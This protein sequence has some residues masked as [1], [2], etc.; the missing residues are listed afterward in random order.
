MS[1]KSG[2]NLIFTI[3]SWL[4]I[5]FCFLLFPAFVLETTVKSYFELKFHNERQNIFTELSRRNESILPF[6]DER[7]YFQKLLQKTFA[8]AENERNSLNYLAKAIQRLKKNYPGQLEF[9]VWNSKGGIVEKLT[10]EKKYKYVLKKLYRVLRDVKNNILSGNPT[11]IKDIQSLK[12]S[13]NIVKQFLGRVFL[14]DTLRFPYLAE[15]KAGLILAD[16]GKERPYFW[17]QIGEK[18]G[19]LTFIKWDLIK[20][21]HGLL[22]L[23]QVVNKNHPD[24]FCGF[25]HIGN[26]SK[27]FPEP[28]P[29]FKNDII[30]GLS[31]FENFA[32][33]FIEQK[34][35]L[36]SIQMINPKIRIFNISQRNNKDF[37]AETRK[38]QILIKIGL[39]YL[40]GLA[41]IIFNFRVR[42]SFL[43][44]R[45]KLLFLFLYANAAPLGVLGFISNDYLQHKKISLKD[46]FNLESAR[47]LRDFDSRFEQQKYDFTQQLNNLVE[48][49]NEKS[50]TQLTDDDE[51][52][53]RTG[54]KKFKVSEIYL[55][56]KNGQTIFTI[57]SSG[58]D[59][60]GTT[61]YFKTIAEAVLKYMN[62]IILKADKSDVFSKITSPEH[63]DY[64]RNS[65]RDSRKIWPISIGESVKLGYWNYLGKPEEYQNNYF[66]LLLWS[67]E[68]FQQIYLK[69]H[70]K[71]L[72]KNSLGTRAFIRSIKTRKL[73]PELDAN[74]SEL[75]RFMNLIEEKQSI[76]TEEI[77]SNG[78]KHLAIGMVGHQLNQMVLC[79]LF[80]T[81]EI[82]KKMKETQ[83]NLLYGCLISI[84]LTTVIG[85][86][87]ARQFMEPV[88]NLS[89]AAVEI[90]KQNYRHRIAEMDKDEFGHLGNVMNRV[91]AGLG[92]MQIAKVV[93]E[94]LFP[95]EHFSQ[96]PFEVFGKSVVM[97]TLGGDYFDFFPLDK[98][99]FGVII[100]D[101]A[102]H[103]VSAALIMAMAKARVK[104]T[105]E[106]Q[107]LNPAELISA[108][109]S[110]ILSLK[111]KK[112]RRMMTFQ[113]LVFN[114]SSGNVSFANAG[115]C[116]P[117]LISPK[118]N[119][120]R[121]IEHIG[122]P[123]GAGKKANYHNQEF[124]LN[125]GESLVLFTDGIIEAQGSNNEP[126]G[127]PG[128]IKIAIKSYDKDPKEYYRK[129]FAAY[130]D[131]AGEADDDTTMIV[132][133]RKCC[134]D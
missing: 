53:L 84:L 108:V 73:F 15:G 39:L 75:R 52:F 41:I 120:A 33:Q 74:S 64:V 129:I 117:L 3:I 42:K 86:L 59:I 127:Y 133:N 1:V 85:L 29:Q 104:M 123:L 116:Y 65:I 66:L 23:S 94:S 68:E 134:H 99:N 93:Q 122:L 61:R 76:C 106:K 119:S 38:N 12:A 71:F 63:S 17:Y 27:V 6:D 24:S 7:K 11:S 97:T 115:H 28:P 95:D 82:E 130:L 37:D 109:H 87:V 83:N 125:E 67:E 124:H 40:L 110:I 89:V 132:I 43:S 4:G 5:I 91:M 57:S 105:T 25:A 77:D 30:L 9:I 98:E 13:L 100:G 131:W 54:L 14:P 31:R 79:N 2:I 112:Q 50:A 81:R 78:E 101:V 80:P 20:G 22:K 128:F 69:N 107:R 72:E 58:K 126:L 32:E 36:I 49:V 44:M 35:S 102:G 96:P 47:L 114:R 70:F 26:I 113:Y 34:N 111:N 118:D 8:M 51:Q 88:R 103:G 45:W 121:F 62:K 55:F 21:H 46:S 10:D 90:N 56:G 16:Y 92:E 60:S 19:I 18:F 48:K